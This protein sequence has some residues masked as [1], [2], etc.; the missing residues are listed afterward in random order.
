MYCDSHWDYCNDYQGWIE[1]LF[2]KELTFGKDSRSK[3]FQ[4][5]PNKL[6]P[7]RESQEWHSYAQSMKYYDRIMKSYVDAQKACAEA[8][9]IYNM[10][11]EFYDDAWKMV[12]KARKSHEKVW[13]ALNKASNACYTARDAYFSKYA[14]ELQALHDKMFPDCTWDGDFY[15]GGVK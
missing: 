13:K 5:I 6:V 4:L 1:Y 11:W 2:I 8:D 10:V 7:G 15:L 14:S 9:K 12:D 3:L